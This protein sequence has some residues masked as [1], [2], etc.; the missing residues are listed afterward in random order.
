M[1]QQSQ[2]TISLG[3]RFDQPTL[4]EKF[5]PLHHEFLV[6]QL[7]DSLLTFADLNFLREVRGKVSGIRDGAGVVRFDVESG[8]L[9]R[10]SVD[11]FLAKLFAAPRDRGIELLNQNSKLIQSPQRP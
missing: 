4:Q 1:V 7:F 3:L 6:L 10:A 2:C 9:V 8:N 11:E 5:V